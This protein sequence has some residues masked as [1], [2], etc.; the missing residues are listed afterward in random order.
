MFWPNLKS[1]ILFV[2]SFYAPLYES[3]LGGLRPVMNAGRLCVKFIIFGSPGIGKSSFGL[4]ALFRALREGRTVVYASGPLKET[5]VLSRSGVRNCYPWFAWP[6][7]EV[8]DPN[9]VLICD[10]VQPPVCA[11]FTLLVTSPKKDIW[12]SFAKSPGCRRLFFPVFSADEIEAMRAA[13]YPTVDDVD[14]VLE[15]YER[16]GG[17]PRYVLGNLDNES[18]DMLESAIKGATL[19]ALLAAMESESVEAE[20]SHRLV[21]F[22]VRGELEEYAEADPRDPDFYRSARA[23][24]ASAYVVRRLHERALEKDAQ[25]LAYFLT[26]T[27]EHPAAAALRGNLFEAHALRLL[28]GG[29]VYEVRHL[30]GPHAP[31]MVPPLPPAVERWFRYV[32]E[33]GGLPPAERDALLLRP[34]SKGFAAIDAVLQGCVFA[35]TTYNVK[36]AI[37]LVGKARRGLTATLDAFGLGTE[38]TITFCWVVPHDVFSRFLVPAPFTEAGKQLSAMEVAGHRVAGRISQYVLCLPPFVDDAG[39]VRKRAR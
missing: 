16:W 24:L 7:P 26:N 38:G 17:V 19:E 25:R 32:S 4:Y 15:R 6:A 31:I 2:R 20:V 14:G 1:S 18:Q 21:H 35:N 8:R 12:Y 34:K 9:T 10:S 5:Y 36:H 37:A 28:S 39:N 11:A 13:C 3:V 22:K 30:S 29:G 27:D 33:V 23:E